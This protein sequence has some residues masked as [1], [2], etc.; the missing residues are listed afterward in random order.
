M[1]K[2]EAT[3]PRE[4][5]SSLEQDLQRILSVGEECI[6]S[7]ELK[8]LITAKG[9]NTEKYAEDDTQ[10]TKRFNTPYTII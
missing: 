3:P 6:S 9:R 2:K 10:K 7:K 8:A 1:P 5:T 4:W